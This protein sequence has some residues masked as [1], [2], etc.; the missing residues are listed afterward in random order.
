MKLFKLWGVLVCAWLAYANYTGWS[1]FAEAGARQAG[2]RS[3]V[4]HK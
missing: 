2:P 3:H 4:Y 1:L